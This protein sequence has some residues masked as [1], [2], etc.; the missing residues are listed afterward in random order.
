MKRHH[1]LLAQT[2][3]WSCEELKELSEAVKTHWLEKEWERAERF[4]S[5]ASDIFIGNVLLRLS[6]VMPGSQ[7]LRWRRVSKRWLSW[8]QQLEH[9][10]LLVED[11]F[12]APITRLDRCFPLVT[13]LKTCCAW[14]DEWNI[15]LTQRLQKLELSTETASG[16]SC[17]HKKH[18][19]SDLVPHL[20]Q[21]KTLLFYD[22]ETP[23]P[24]IELLTGLTH[25]VISGEAFDKK[26]EHLLAL[27]NLVRLELMD[28]P[29]DWPVW[30]L[31]NLKHLRSDCLNHFYGFTG[32]GRCDDEGEYGAV[33]DARIALKTKL[34]PCCWTA[35][36]KGSWVEGVFSG[37]AHVSYSNYDDIGDY[38]NDDNPDKTEMFYRGDVVEDRWQGYGRE[39]H[40]YA[41]PYYDGQWLESKRHG[42]GRIARAAVK[43][44]QVFEEVI[45]EGEWRND[46]FVLQPGSV[47]ENT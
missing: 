5:Q 7:L 14:L 38:N 12:W 45:K 20:T 4:F 22:I 17:L 39:G 24:G 29:R 33:G 15:P 32:E 27:T 21:L 46:N 10:Q 43:G 31:P 34:L 44:N 3:T 40:T 9:V 23:L 25:L 41:G 18:S 8:I 19:I 2:E 42:K 30:E 47:E 13:S 35:T 16:H 6:A 11:Y 37:H 26:R 28:T 36:L 1:Q